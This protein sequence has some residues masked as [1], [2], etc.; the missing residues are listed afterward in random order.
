MFIQGTIGW[1]NLG[2]RKKE[3]FL[4]APTTLIDDPLVSSF[5]NISTLVTFYGKW[6]NDF[7]Q[8]PLST[9]LFYEQR[10]ATYKKPL[11]M[12]YNIHT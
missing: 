9:P 8:T 3:H 12:L 10:F 7:Q 11:H 1:S 6:V 5:I 2:S 4:E